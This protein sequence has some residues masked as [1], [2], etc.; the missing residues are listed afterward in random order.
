[1]CVFVHGSQ[2]FRKSQLSSSESYPSGF[3]DSRSVNLRS[4]ALSVMWRILSQQ[5]V[6]AV[7]TRGCRK[8]RL[9]CLSKGRVE[10]VYLSCSQIYSP[11]LFKTQVKFPRQQHHESI[12]TP[13]QSR[14]FIFDL[15][16]RTYLLQTLWL[17]G[18]GILKYA[19]RTMFIT[20]PVLI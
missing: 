7:N 16:G 20:L 19:W 11:S 1:M 5:S 3:F 6:K 2:I 18:N 10:G 14:E 13:T 15:T 8:R 17:A 4:S 9:R 12:P